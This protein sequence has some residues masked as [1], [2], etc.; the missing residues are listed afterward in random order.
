MRSLSLGF[1]L[2]AFWLALSGHYTPFLI[3]AGVLVSALA[4]WM[5]GRMDILDP[6]GHPIGWLLRAP[7]YF[8]WLIVEIVKSALF[9]SWK[10][11]SWSPVLS[12]TMTTVKAR[13]KTAVG[14]ATFAN[15]ITLT[16]GTISCA[17]DGDRITVHALTSDGARDVETG[18]MNR[19]VAEFEGS[20]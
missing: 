9:V 19:K 14:V 17:V 13:Q 2:L 15:S 7:R 5:A 4:V 6:E 1:T 12:P 18:E 11:I 3:A 8:V 10:I 16:P 20:A